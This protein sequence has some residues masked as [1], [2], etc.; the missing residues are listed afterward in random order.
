MV[1]NRKILE[2]NAMNNHPLVWVIIGVSGSGKTTVGRLLAQK[3]ECDFLE[4]DRRHP[5][6]NVIK[7]S[8]QQPL[9]EKDRLP[10]LS[11]IEDDL[12]RAIDLNREIVVTCSALKASHRKQLISLGRVQLVWLD[13]DILILEQRLKERSKHYMKPEMLPSQIITFEA[14]SLE[15]NV[16]NVN[17]NIPIDVVMSELITKI[18]QRFPIMK[19]AWWERYIRV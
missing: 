13:V 8:L 6:A 9:E 18:I 11:A 7:M 10:W 19:K 16:I 2:E 5:I 12:R 3:L 14:I 4:S 17:G 15:E 1:S